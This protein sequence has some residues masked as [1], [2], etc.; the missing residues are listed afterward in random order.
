MSVPY[1]LGCLKGQINTCYVY[2]DNSDTNPNN[3]FLIK[4][5]IRQ[6]TGEEYKTVN[7][8]ILELHGQNHRDTGSLEYMKYLIIHLGNRIDIIDMD[9]LCFVVPKNG[10][11]LNSAVLNDKMEYKG[12]IDETNPVILKKGMVWHVGNSAYES[13]KIVYNTESHGEVTVVLSLFHDPDIRNGINL[14]V[15]RNLRKDTA[16][17]ALVRA[18]D[19]KLLYVKKS[20][21]IP[22]IKTSLQMKEFNENDYWEICNGYS[23]RNGCP[24]E[25]K[26]MIK[27]GTSKKYGYRVR[28]SQ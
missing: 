3:R 2:F 11:S 13:R 25:T 8:K 4:G 19:P 15:Q 22:V 1:Q 7:Q 21:H 26:Q 24:K 9:K 27:K 10:Y 28:S 16:W 20:T 17:G 5:T 18:A 12:E 23:D 6:L 14:K